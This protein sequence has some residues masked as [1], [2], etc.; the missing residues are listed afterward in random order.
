MQGRKNDTETNETEEQEDTE[1]KQP[2]KK[3]IKPTWLPV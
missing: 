1:E 2:W 3:Y